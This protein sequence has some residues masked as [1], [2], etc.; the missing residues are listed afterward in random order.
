MT[1]LVYDKDINATY[2]TL[3]KNKIAKTQTLGPNL[4]IDFDENNQPVGIE[5][6]GKV[7]DLPPHFQDADTLKALLGIFAAKQLLEILTSLEHRR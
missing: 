7:E 4:Y 5:Y 6:L 2:I 1:D 3:T